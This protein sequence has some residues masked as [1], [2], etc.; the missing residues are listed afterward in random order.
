MQKPKSTFLTIVVI[1][2]VIGIGFFVLGRPGHV[3]ACGYGS[4]GGG[5]YAPQQR[6][7][8]GYMAQK[9]SITKEQAYEL[10][11]SHVKRLNPNLTVGQINDA[12]NFYEAEI[13]SKDN[14]VIQLIGVDKFSGRMMLIN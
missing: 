12:G 6:K 11:S 14:E 5:D 8:D 10:V 7:S 2:A 13:L 4:Q 9:Q 3:G 1:S